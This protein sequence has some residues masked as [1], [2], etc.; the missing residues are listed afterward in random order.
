MKLSYTAQDPSFTIRSL[1]FGLSGMHGGYDPNHLR[2]YTAL[3][4]DA[5]GQLGPLTIRA[6]IS[7]MRDEGLLPKGK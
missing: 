2:D 4:V 5:T 1:T 6:A 7:W 3:G